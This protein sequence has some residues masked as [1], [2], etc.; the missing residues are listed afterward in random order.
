LNL[1]NPITYNEKLQWLKIYDRNPLYS[2]MVDKYEV[3][4]Y[5]SQKIGSEY[6]IP[7][8]GIYK[9]FDQID[10]D[11]LPERFIIKCTHDSGSTFIVNN[12]ASIDKKALRKRI[13]KHLKT[14]YYYKY[15]EWPYKNV[16][17]R[18]I[19]EELLTDGS[20]QLDDYK[21][22]CFN[23]K[24]KLIEVHKG[25][26]GDHTQNFYDVTWEKTTIS[27][28][29]IPQY[30][31][32]NKPATLSEMITLSEKLAIG[33]KHVRIDW[34]SIKDRLFFGEITFYDGSGFDMFTDESDD[35]MLGTWI[36]I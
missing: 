33:F 28:A 18:I 24:A 10:F 29:G 36:D 25:R 13:S 14:N 35:I 4:K 16:Q 2:N 3:K 32:C 15:R 17:P 27:Q 11:L 1:N 7:S 22:L 31:A 21:V 6:I 9:D 12:K 20:A 30:T 5:I 19:C 26:Y 8:L 34:Y 23:G